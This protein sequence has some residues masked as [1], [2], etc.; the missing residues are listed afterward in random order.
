VSVAGGPQDEG[1]ARPRVQD[2][3]V[4][5][6]PW[7]LGG[8]AGNSAI[9]LLSAVV[10]AR[11]LTP[12]DF[13]LVA[14][15]IIAVA[16]LNILS[17]LGLTSTLVVRQDFDRRAQGTVLTLLLVMGVAVSLLLVLLAPLAAELFD[18]PRLTGVLRAL[19]ALAAVSG[20][21]WFYDMVVQR[22]LQFRKR[23]TAQ[24]ARNLGYATVALSL[25][26]LGAG[27][28][29]L[30]AGQL[31][32]AVVYSV[33]LV[34]V[35]PYHVVPS[36][37]RSVARSALASGRGFMVQAGATTV[38]ANLD[39]LVV[40][41]V[42]GVAELGAYSMAYRL[43]EVPYAAIADPIARVT[44]PAFARMRHAGE[45]V[46]A[47]FLRSLRL[48]CL[49]SW[50]LGL[51]L[52]AAADPFTRA[53]FGER[54]LA[55]VAPLS[56]L[57]IWAALRP[58]ET[59]VGWLL[60]A[61]GQ[62]GRNAKITTLLLVP[63]VGAL[64]VAAKLG[65]LTAVACVVLAHLTL[66]IGAQV[67]VSQRHLELSALAQWRAVRALLPA[68]ASCWLATHLAVYA[69]GAMAAGLTLAIATAVGV[70]TYLAL[71]AVTDRALLHTTVSDIRRSLGRGQSGVG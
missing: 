69:T 4:R 34:W 61:L 11:L 55:M 25:A 1:A 53:I 14:L 32:G 64:V 38:E 9:T 47:A 26:A 45:D 60:N 27:V 50:P 20:F 5:G 63:L 22:E 35:A 49:L 12:A 68:A 71:I 52:S 66:V 29:S 65:G 21:Y 30:V 15:A 56:V 59:M 2:Q 39:Y 37:E 62:A 48:V 17:D 41:R 43:G 18:Q 3:A 13:G 23:F 6:V 7:A 24:L 54:W 33:A 36:F 19:A 58:L 10:L 16:A 42:L 67:W 31:A 40:G 44:F 46:G 28:W 70:T 57:G 51:I 8:Y